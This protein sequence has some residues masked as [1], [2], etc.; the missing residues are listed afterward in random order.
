[1]KTS[2]GELLDATA[3]SSV[4]LEMAAPDTSDGREWAPNDGG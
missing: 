1:M 4:E 2:A 3:R